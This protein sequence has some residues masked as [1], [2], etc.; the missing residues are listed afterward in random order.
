[1]LAHQFRVLGRVGREELAL[2]ELDRLLASLAVEM[3]RHDF[4]EQN[5]MKN[6]NARHS[7]SNMEEMLSEYE[8]RSD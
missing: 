8:T 4:G 7:K 1:M 6:K 5:A 2:I 3:R